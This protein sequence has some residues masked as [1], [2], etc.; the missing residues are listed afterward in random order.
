MEYL[1]N[2]SE[3]DFNE[4]EILHTLYEQM[5][6]DYFEGNDTSLTNILDISIKALR[7]QHRWTEDEF[8]RLDFPLVNFL[9][10]GIISASAPWMA[11]EDA[12]DGEIEAFDGAVLAEGL[13]GVLGAGGRETAAGLLE[14]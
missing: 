7:N 5:S 9:R 2:N 13:E 4:K 12:S 3:F 11:A 8:E 14:R 10:H 6:V 1:I